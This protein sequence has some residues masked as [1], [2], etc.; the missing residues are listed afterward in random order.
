M[1]VAGLTGGLA[2]GKTFVASAFAE[3]GCH[4][5]EADQLGHAVIQEECREEIAAVF[6][7]TDRQALGRLVFSDPQR[8]AQL[9]AI[10]HPAVRHRA[11]KKIHEIGRSDARAIVVY[12][13]AILVETGTAEEFDKLIVVNC[14]REQQIERAMARGMSEQ[15]AL[16]RL[17][18]QLPTEDKLK[19]ADYVIDTSGSTEA[20]LEQTKM[21]YAQLRELVR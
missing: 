3:L 18:R 20:T 14:T 5:L 10:V 6:G 12:V 21:V 13:A 11:L 15:D 19:V 8:L 7:V 4:V 9:N 16:A 17:A 1:L 2:T